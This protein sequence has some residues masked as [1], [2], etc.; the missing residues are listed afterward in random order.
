[1]YFLTFAVRLTIGKLPNVH[2]ETGIRDE[3]VP[4]KVLMKF[5]ANIDPRRKMKAVMGVNGVAS[6][7]GVVKVGDRVRVKKYLSVVGP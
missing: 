2:P 5:R 4:F 6:A 3:A 7:S 1:M